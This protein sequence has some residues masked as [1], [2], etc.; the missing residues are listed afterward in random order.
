MKEILDEQRIISL[1]RAKRGAKIG[2]IT[3]LAFAGSSIVLA[4]LAD[5]VGEQKMLSQMIEQPTEAL[6]GLSYLTARLTIPLAVV[7]GLIDS[8]KPTSRLAKWTI[9]KEVDSFI[10]LKNGLISLKNSLV[11]TRQFYSIFHTI[12]RPKLSPEW[13][14]RKGVT[15]TSATIT[16]AVAGGIS[17]MLSTEWVGLDWLSQKIGVSSAP[18]FVST[19]PSFI[20][21]HP[22]ETIGIGAALGLAGSTYAMLAA[23]PIESENQ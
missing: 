18:S 9:N 14:D 22:L 4:G 16:G 15:I 11:N 10:E 3:G 1:D 6:L 8:F 5:V 23:K 7:C 2:V 21:T 17:W 12:L 19:I 13:L 20:F